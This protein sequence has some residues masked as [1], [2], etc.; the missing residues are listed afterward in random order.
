MD[1]SKVL[2][3]VKTYVI[4]TFA[5]VLLDL[6]VYLFKFPNNFSFGG[7][8]GM[9]VVVAH[10]TPLSPSLFN[11]IMNMA[12]LIFGFI[13][14]GRDFGIKTVYVSVLSSLLLSL[15]EQVF[16]MS[17]AL[18]DQ[19]VLELVFA[20]ALP[21]VSAALL[22]NQGASGGGTD[23]IALIIKKYSS[24]NIG[25]ALFIVDLII[26]CAACIVFDIQTG[27]FSFTGLVVKSLVID[28]VIEDL[29]LSKYFTIICENPEPILA[30]IR[31]ELKRGATV[32]RAEGAYSH[33]EKTVILS[34]IKRSE[35]AA[36]RRAIHKIDP[37]AFTMITNSSEIFGKN[38]GSLNI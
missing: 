38:F 30:Y 32:Y 19:P 7:V 18:T 22:F 6:G 23:I 17:G 11:L 3:T 21:A 4:L 2:K 20:I 10:L 8:T 12:L 28:G 26:T 25:S 27:L 31:D 14:L 9:A 33:T 15:M 37:T 5:T 34:V 1:K 24:F 35:S 16:P 13:F 36:L 29:N